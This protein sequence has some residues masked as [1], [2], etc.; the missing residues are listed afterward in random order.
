MDLG[1]HG[2]C[3]SFF[4]DVDHL[5]SLIIAYDLYRYIIPINAPAPTVKVKRDARKR[6]P[7]LKFLRRAGLGSTEFG[8]SDRRCD[9]I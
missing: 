8:I 6:A 3:V 5:V 9:M 1:N 7:F 2:L 4:S